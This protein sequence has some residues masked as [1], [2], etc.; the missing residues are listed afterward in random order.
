MNDAATAASNRFTLRVQGHQLQEQRDGSSDCAWNPNTSATS[1]SP[2]SAVDEAMGQQA[3]RS[4]RLKK[5]SVALHTTCAPLAS[6]DPPPG[7]TAPAATRLPT[8]MAPAG[9]GHPLRDYYARQ[10][11]GGKNAHTRTRLHT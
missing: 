8:R 3:S 2:L 5:V 1:S 7:R 10:A 9:A 4:G 11:P 6:A